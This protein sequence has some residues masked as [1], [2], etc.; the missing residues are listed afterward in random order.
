MY[1]YIY[2]RRKGGL[3][4]APARSIELM[5]YDFFFVE[6]IN[7]SPPEQV[8][9]YFILTT[10]RAALLR[11]NIVQKNVQKS[12]KN[13]PRKNIEQITPKYASWLQKW[14]HLGAMCPGLSAGGA[15][16]SRPDSRNLC[17]VTPWSPFGSF[18]A[19]FGLHL[20]RFGNPLSPP[21]LFRV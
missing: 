11:Y 6:F 2:T 1:I 8:K 13:Q 14:W 3:K 16:F 10:C 17:G 4:P 7:Y 12:M 19:P 15:S 20:G 21:Y 9:I 5:I 18:L